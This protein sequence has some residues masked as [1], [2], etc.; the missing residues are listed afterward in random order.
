MERR[1]HLNHLE[2]TRSVHS[3]NIQTR[4][5]ASRWIVRITFGLQQDA[6]H[7]GPTTGHSDLLY[8]L[9]RIPNGG[10]D[11]LS[12]S[13]SYVVA[14]GVN[15]FDKTELGQ[16]AINNECQTCTFESENIL[17]ELD[18]EGQPT[19]D[20]VVTG[21]FTNLQ[22]IPG[23]HLL[24][25]PN[26]VSPA[27]AQVCFGNGQQTL[28]LN[29]PLNNGDSFEVGADASN[30]EAIIIKNAMPGDEVCFRIILRGDNGIECC[31]VEVCFEMPPCDCLQVDRRLNR[32]TNVV[33]NGDGTVD[34]SYTFQLTNL[35]GQDVYH[36]FLASNGSELFN[37]DYFDLV[38]ANG[39]APLG[40]GQS[41]SL[42]TI[43]SG[44]QPEDLV[45][46]LIV[47]HL[48]D[49]SECCS[50]HHD[51]LSPA[52]DNGMGDVPVSVLLGDV[53][54]D[55]A[56]DFLDIGPFISL[57]SN[58]EFKEEA[59]IDQNGEVNFM[60]IASFIAVLSGQ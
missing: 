37:P 19:G 22:D 55:G 21:L 51:V 16:V 52:A 34:F 23:T 1:G 43:V 59:D 27:G 18:A 20:F 40:Q 17:C 11:G 26:A 50:R 39:G 10:N 60:D 48:E 13:T 31:T 9:Q 41:V 12:T 6:I 58:G 46:F 35:F 49:F 29:S 38:A 32:I 57:L 3:S 33:S 36:A 42:T 25:P 2:N 30:E 56:V 28:Q 53:N 8:G 7:F 54:M 15:E 47:I 24:I 14:F 5:A 44:A 4:Q 45:S